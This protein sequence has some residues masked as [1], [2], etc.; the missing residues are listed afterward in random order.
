[1]PDTAANQACYPQ[2]SSQASG[3][4]SPLARLVGVICLST[5]ALL[6]SALGPHAGK[7]TSELGL[8]RRL[9]S[10]FAAGD[11]MLADAFYC[12]YFLI[13]ALQADSATN[14]SHF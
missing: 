1:M 11:V 6:D 8:L 2:P 13:A 4:G 14:S 5:G 10:A 12:N 9:A 3:V 7:G